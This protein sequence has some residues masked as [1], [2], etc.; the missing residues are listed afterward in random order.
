[1]NCR[2]IQESGRVQQLRSLLAV[3]FQHLCS[4]P[5]KVIPPLQTTP[6]KHAFVNA[7]TIH[8][9]F[10]SMHNIGVIAEPKRCK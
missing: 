9:T 7:D 6:F 5:R 10:G 3:D 2:C 1:M 4:G 8:K